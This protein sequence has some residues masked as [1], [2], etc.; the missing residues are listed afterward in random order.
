MIA[1]LLKLPKRQGIYR[2]WQTAEGLAVTH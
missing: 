1:N 2:C